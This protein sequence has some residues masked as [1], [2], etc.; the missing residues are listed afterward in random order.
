[1]LSLVTATVAAAFPVLVVWAGAVDAVS[2][3]I[4]NSVAMM[5][6]VCFCLF[7][8]STGLSLRDVGTHFLC[9]ASILV[10][11]Y[12]L[13]YF[14]LLGGGDAKLL[15]GSALWFGFDQLLPF[16][17]SVALAGG[18]LSLCLAA[19]HVIR[20]ALGF[21]A[22]D[23]RAVPFGVAIAAAVLAVLPE[24]IISF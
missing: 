2:R 7:A 4:P 22:T 5:L 15:A 21:S 24:W 12:I 11:G 1:M 6:A 17:A 19:G 16:L 8:A 3:T 13:F 10:G 20:A 18:A 9:A 14:S 23:G